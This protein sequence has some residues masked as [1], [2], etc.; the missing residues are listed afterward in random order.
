MKK[1]QNKSAK[2]PKKVSIYQ[3]DILG[4]NISNNMISFSNTGN[5]QIPCEK[6]EQ[7]K[8]EKKKTTQNQTRCVCETLMPPK[9]LSFEKHDPD[10]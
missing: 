7:N 4:L 1:G 2:K 8:S 3:F 9:P 5:K 10:I 6:K